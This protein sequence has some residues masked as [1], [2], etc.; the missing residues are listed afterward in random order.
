MTK[1]TTNTNM[2]ERV[3]EIAAIQRQLADLLNAT[4]AKVRELE[5]AMSDKA[6]ELEDLVTRRGN[7][8]AAAEIAEAFAEYRVDTGE[9]NSRLIDAIERRGH[10]VF[11][12]KYEPIRPDW[13]MIENRA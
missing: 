12:P 1:T 9:L 8:N 2:N 10:A 7:R 5:I 3:R 6:N 4:G 13:K 11:P